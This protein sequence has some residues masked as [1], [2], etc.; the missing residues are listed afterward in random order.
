[1]AKEGELIVNAGHRVMEGQ[2]RNKVIV[3]QVS[4]DCMDIK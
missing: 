1:M 3:M 2:N 4:L